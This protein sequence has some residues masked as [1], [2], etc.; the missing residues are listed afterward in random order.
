MISIRY[1]IAGAIFG[2][3][4]G[5]AMG[6]P[7]EFVGSFEAIRARWPPDGVTGFE[8]YWERG[9]QRFAPYTDDTDMGLVVLRSLLAAREDGLDLD[10][11]MTSMAAAFIEWSHQPDLGSRA[12]GNACLAGC[13]R[14]ES[15]AHWAEGGTPDS[16]GCGSIMRVYP[17]ALVHMDAPERALAWSVE[18]SKLTHRAPMALAACAGMTGAMLALLAGDGAPAALEAMAAAADDHDA[19]TAE[20][21]RGAIAEARAGTPPEDILDRLQGWNAREALAASAY[22]FA[23]NPGDPR[24]AILEGANS[25]GDSDSIACIAG[26]LA[27][28]ACGAEAIPAEWRREVEGVDELQALADRVAT[29]QGV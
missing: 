8:K 4:V 23:R 24:A 6:H 16:G 29:L 10:G 25:P 15:G 9:G 17:F 18:H 14:L 20:L 27:G 13:H 21:T 7:T 1:R 5:D 26:S 19:E 3:A 28:A 22:V 12:P 11:T 2:G